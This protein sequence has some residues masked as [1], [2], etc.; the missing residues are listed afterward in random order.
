M[1]TEKR[2]AK[3]ARVFK[4]SLLVLA[5]VSLVKIAFFPSA[6]EPAMIAE[7]DFAPPTTTLTQ[8]SI[9]S[10]KKL[11]ASILRDAPV[12]VRA[13]ASGEV[14]SVFVG[15]GQTVNSGQGLIQ[16][17]KTTMPA[18]GAASGAAGTGPGAGGNGEAGEAESTQSAPQPVVTY[19]N[20]AA[21]SGG[22]VELNVVL[23]QNVE[24]GQEI[25]VISPGR[26]HAVAQLKPSQLYS[27]GEGLQS[28]KL[29]ITDGPAPFL[30]TEVK[31][32]ASS[33]GAAAG[34]G[35]AG[36]AAGAG[37]SASSGAAASGS[38]SGPQ[39][40][41]G[42]PDDQT[43]YEGIPATLTIGGATTGE[44]P[45]LPV[46]AVEGRFNEGVVFIPSSDPAKKPTKRKVEL[47]HN[48]GTNIEIKGGLKEGEE[49]LMFVPSSAA[50]PDDP[51]SDG[52]EGSDAPAAN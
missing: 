27:M 43:V 34:T 32:V 25:G 47:G 17:K 44:V 52:G 14:T 29:A 26:F 16:V 22:T 20:I 38:G 6:E 50:D 33:S 7:G 19:Q 28:G 4:Y 39:I 35:A 36:G 8:A 49:V 46:T 13:T 24:A 10:E 3:I 15:S 30:C 2:G 51:N 31:I 48:D 11:P 41:C 37:A 42:I 5:T 9:N 18:G 23:G 21:Q 45:T 40:R 1:K 12:P